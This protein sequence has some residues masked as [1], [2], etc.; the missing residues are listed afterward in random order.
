MEPDEAILDPDPGPGSWSNWSRV[1]LGHEEV[2][3]DFAAVDPFDETRAQTVA[4][5]VIPPGAGF[6][7]RDALISALEGYTERG[8]P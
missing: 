7:L 1:A 4:R 5:I 8:R 6:E 3:I 2:T